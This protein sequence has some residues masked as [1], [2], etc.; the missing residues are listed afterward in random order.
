[1]EGLATLN[2]QDLLAHSAPR[3]GAEPQRYEEHISE[4][5]RGARLRADAM[6]T[7]GVPELQ[8]MAGAV[9]AAAVFHDLGKLSQGNQAAL[10]QGRG[11]KLS[12]DHIDAGVA[13]LSAAGNWM[14]A[15]LVRAHHSP[16]FPSLR[17]HFDKDGLGRR[18]RGHR[19]DDEPNAIHDSLIAESDAHLGA[20]LADHESAVGAFD[21]STTRPFHGMAMRLA[22]SCL[23]DADHADTSRFDSGDEVAEAPKLRWEERLRR[24][25]EYVRSLASGGSL[26]RDEHRNEFYHACRDSN[27]VDAIVSCEGPVGIGKTTAITAYLLNRAASEGLR[28]IIVVAPYTNI[29]T[30][31][32]RKLRD[33]LVLDGEVPE[34]VVVEHHHRADFETRGARELAVLWR[35]PVVVTTA[36]QFFETLGSNNPAEL[37]K[38]HALPGSAVFLDE[39]HAALPAHLWRQNWLWVRELTQRWTCR[40][41]LASGS[42]AR[43]WENPDIVD[44]PERIPE[45]VSSELKQAI[46]PAERRRVRYVQA[47]HSETL[48]ELIQT[49]GEAE[50]PRLVI[51]NTV[52]S[53]ALVAREMRIRGNAVLHLSTALAPQDRTKILGDV[54][55]RLD[56]VRNKNWSLIA[57]SCVEAGIDLSFQNAFRERFSSASLIQVGGRVNRHGGSE[58]GTVFDFTIDAGAGITKHP[59]ARY[60]AAVLKRQLAAGL[61][62]RGNHDPAEIVTRAMAEEVKDRGGLGHDHLSEAEAFRDYPA[63][64]DAARVIDADTRLVVVDPDLAAQLELPK[65]VRFRELLAGSVQIWTHKVGALNLNP[66]PGRPDIYRWPYAYDSAFLGYMAGVLQQFDLGKEGFAII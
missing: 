64:R 58:I 49:V 24:L 61:F 63:V 42:L 19:R 28:R 41:V 13:H 14:A 31:T 29:I 50:G 36:V 4:V 27:V 34:E 46:L 32:A 44:S 26:E 8:F 52:Q 54:S 59:A 53:A 18:L 60:P 11:S 15:W 56:D 3:P 47:G 37:R 22:L 66:V 23:V 6:L 21:V 16:G 62:E 33:A 65:P 20:Y 40:F 10:A 5:R 43:F 7:F 51:L 57:T 55:K 1:M 35:A 30:Q 45:L 12:W 17:T 39:A 38:L 48:P 2:R 25:D 9:E